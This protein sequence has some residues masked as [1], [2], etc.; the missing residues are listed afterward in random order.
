MRVDPATHIVWATSNEDGNPVIE[1]YD[2]SN[3]ALKNY[4]FDAPIHGGG[5]DDMAFINGQMIVADSAP[6]TDDAG[7]LIPAP[8]LSE[9]HVNGSNITFT[10]VLM[11]DATAID[12]SAP[13]DAGPVALNLT[14]PDSLSID[15]KGR[16]VLVDQGD[17]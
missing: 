16:L 9:V 6:A 10:P 17:S 1:S 8:A 7:N 15:D 4:T 11:G 3:G 12:L 14:D 13:A 2:P 5:L